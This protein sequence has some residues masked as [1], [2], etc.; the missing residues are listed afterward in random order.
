MQRRYAIMILIASVFVSFA[1][2]ISVDMSGYEL[3]ALINLFWPLFIGLISLILLLLCLWLIKNQ[4]I[5]VIII[6]ILALYNIY[7]GLALHLEK[8]YWPLVIW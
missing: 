6:I 3:G 8:E 4:K 7:V 1:L 5:T 2:A